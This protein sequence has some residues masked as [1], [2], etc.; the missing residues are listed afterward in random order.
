V[1]LAA[2]GALRR[3]LTLALHSLLVNIF[4][5]ISYYAMASGVGKVL[6]HSPGHH[7]TVREV[8]SRCVCAALR[9]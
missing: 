6:V 5:A 9:T 2:S 3:W 7:S 1:V 8:S 4:A